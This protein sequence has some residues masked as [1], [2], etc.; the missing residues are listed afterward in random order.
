MVHA[1][2]HENKTRG[3]FV[4]YDYF[5]QTS[6]ISESRSPVV[7]LTYVKRI[8]HVVCTFKIHILI[9]LNTY[10]LGQISEFVALLFLENFKVKEFHPHLM[11]T[12][13]LLDCNMHSKYLN[14]IVNISTNI[15]NFYVSRHVWGIGEIFHDYLALPSPLFTFSPN[16]N[17]LISLYFV[18]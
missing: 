13:D 2:I 11:L 3:T 14:Y 10:G 1:E 4:M 8:V 5:W 9:L 17:Y 6:K 12:K 7:P 18:F 15:S 16:K